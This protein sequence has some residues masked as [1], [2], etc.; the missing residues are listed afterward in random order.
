MKIAKTDRSRIETAQRC[1]RLRWHQYHDGPE[2]I[3][4]QSAKTPLPLVV[5]LAVHKGLEI[6]LREGQALR[7]KYAHS[8][9]DEIVCTRSWTEIEEHAVADALAD[10]SQYTGALELDTTEAAQLSPTT[11]SES[12][13]QQLAGSLGLSPED[14]GLGNLEQ[15]FAASR[16]QFD[17]Y[18][19]KEQAAL[20]EALVRAY[21]RRRLRPLLEQFVVLEVEREGEWMLS[22]W[23]GTTDTDPDVATP[24]DW[25]LWFMSRPDALL[26]ERESQQLYILSFKTAAQWDIRKE[27]DAQHDM[28]GISEAIEPERRLA[29]WW[30]QVNEGDTFKAQLGFDIPTPMYKFLRSQPA[31]PRILAIRYEYILKGERWTDKDLSLR[32]GLTAR[33]QRSP[34]IRKYVAHSVPQTKTA[35]PP[36]AHGAVCVSWDYVRPDDMKESK[37]AW[38]N[39]KSEP[40]WESG[41]IHDWI[42]KLDASHEV[43]SAEDST[44]GME[45]RMLGW[46][47]DAQALG[48]LQQHPL[49]QV[50]IPPITVYRNEDEARDWLEET[51][52]QER[53]IAEAVELVHAA[54]D[55][56]ERRTQLN[57]HFGKTRRACE[58]P[59]TCSMVKVC[60]NDTVK[61]DPIGSGLYKVRKVNHPM[62]LVQIGNA[63]SVSQGRGQ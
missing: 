23:D 41:T 32:T 15:R 3:G 21:A 10:F 57:I 13:T 59:T 14:A 42:D 18:L 6:L 8:N 1:A 46:K 49:D 45:P 60:W 19:E 28:Q 52:A 25:Q 47:S 43:M 44:V 12:F 50:F 5:G 63:V 33:T 16:N 38:Q 34:L 26:L 20:V 53:R 2:R 48:V 56:G 39:W 22:K 54:P 36:F 30:H 51:E 55:E 58:Y 40:V 17:E 11:T 37:L 4:I 35:T 7:D 62:E 31:P 27:R 9:L 24:Y 61:A 29:E